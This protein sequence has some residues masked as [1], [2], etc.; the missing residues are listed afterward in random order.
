MTAHRD[1]KKIIRDR[2]QKTGESYSTA[3]AHVMRARSERLGLSPEA[4]VRPENAKMAAVTG[5]WRSVSWRLGLHLCLAKSPSV[6]A[7]RPVDER[8]S[9]RCGLTRT[10]R[11]RK[12]RLGEAPGRTPSSDRLDGSE[13]SREDQ[14]VG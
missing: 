8:R 9:G 13:E 12:G 11:L 3:R 7:V 5:V 14:V 10:A 2:Q 6:G 4:P 1:L